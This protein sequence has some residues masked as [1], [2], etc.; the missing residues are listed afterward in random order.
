MI[1]AV[2]KVY[3]RRGEVLAP[4]S[5]AGISI[6]DLYRQLLTLAP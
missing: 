3:T 2:L 1:C 5:M 4:V 6:E